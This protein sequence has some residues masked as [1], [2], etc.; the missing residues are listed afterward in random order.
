MER[1][2]NK[3]SRYAEDKYCKPDKCNEF[4]G[5]PNFKSKED[6]RYEMKV[7]KFGCYI[8]DLKDGRD[9][10]LIETLQ[11]MNDYARDCK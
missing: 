2:C 11:I 8:Y 6:E 7:G 1:D 3:C 5:F 9:I 10:D 4:K